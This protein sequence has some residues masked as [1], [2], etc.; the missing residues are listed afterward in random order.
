MALAARRQAVV[1][2]TRGYFVSTVALAIK[3][4]D[5]RRMEPINLWR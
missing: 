4:D 1:T 2:P 5:D 3:E